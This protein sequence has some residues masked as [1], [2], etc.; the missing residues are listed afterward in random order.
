MPLTIVRQDI[1]RM[2]T[3]AIV[4]AANTGLLMGGGVCGA[5]FHAAGEEELRAACAAQAPIE[6]GAAAITPG[7]ALPAKYIIHTAGPV[8]RDGK[9]GEEALLRACYT[10][11]LNLALENGCVSIAFP[12][13]SSGLYG[14]PKA[15]ALAAARGAILEFLEDKEMD[16]FLLVFD[17][18]AFRAS[19]SLMAEV[20]SFISSSY[21][22]ERGRSRRRR[23]Q[24]EKSLPVR[25]EQEI[26]L[27]ELREINADTCARY[28]MPS[29]GLDEM[30]GEL[31]EPFS[32]TLLR[33]IDLKGETDAAVYKRANLDRRLFSKIRSNKD[34]MPSRR[35]AIAL[36]IALKL[37]LRETESL[38]SCAGYT[39]SNSQKFDAIIRYFITR[40][41]YDIFE[42]NEVLFQL[43]Q[44]LLGGSA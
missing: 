17:K 19:A 42:I 39:L 13:I 36:A 25:G 18:E 38:L 31:D 9:Q 23:L 41:R 2:G 30:L 15:E 29:T 35:T 7:F 32:T 33:L 37:N 12:L 11:S 14:Y 28:P 10:N 22:E 27:N 43:D 3:D 20:Q 34:Y 21:A 5:I 4:N 24:F 26:F 1:T 40:G 44:P 6:V 16:V 8:Y